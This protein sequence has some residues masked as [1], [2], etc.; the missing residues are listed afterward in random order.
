MRVLVVLVVV[1]SIS[2]IGCNSAPRCSPPSQT[3]Y[4]CAPSSTDDAGCHGGPAFGG[5]AAKR[6]VQ[7][8]DSAVIS[9]SLRTRRT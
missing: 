8:F 4:D 3:L 5:M 9:L 1:T 6:C 2:S 7:R